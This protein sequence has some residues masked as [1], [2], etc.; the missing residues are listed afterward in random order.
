MG[1]PAVTD[2]SAAA[3]R[4][5][6]VYRRAK[7]AAESSLHCAGAVVRALPRAGQAIDCELMKKTTTTF[8]DRI[9]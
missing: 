9:T 7:R 4:A 8:C 3:M 5:A 6:N 1:K 2:R